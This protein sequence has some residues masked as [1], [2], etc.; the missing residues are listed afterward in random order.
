MHLRALLGMM[1]ALYVLWIIGGGL[2]QRLAGVA[3]RRWAERTAANWRLRFY[4]L[5]VLM[6]M[7]EE[8]ITT[9]ITNLAPLLGVQVGEVYITASSNYW[10]V[11]MGHSLVVILP[12]F[13]AWVW[14]LSRYKFDP[15]QVLLLFGLTGTAME[16]VYGGVQQLLQA[17]MWIFVYGLMVYLPACAVPSNRVARIPR[18]QHCI[19]A[20]ILPFVLMPLCLPLILLSRTIRP[21]S[22]TEFTPIVLSRSSCK[23]L[24]NTLLIGKRTVNSGSSR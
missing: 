20:V 17:G 22:A 21:S 2:T 15:V 11:I 5:C 1:D 4:F 7:L 24:V 16:T 10:D 3:V 8:A 19:L 13:L 23:R 9:L 12:A 6:A 18:F 14:I